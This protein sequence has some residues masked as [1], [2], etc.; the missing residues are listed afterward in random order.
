MKQYYFFFLVSFITAFAY[1]PPVTG[2]NFKDLPN[3]ELKLARVRDEFTKGSNA[4]ALQHVNLLINEYPGYLDAYVLRGDINANPR[5]YKVALD[6]YNFVLNNHPATA[7][8]CNCYWAMA[9]VYDNYFHDKPHAISLYTTYID[10]EL[11]DG[12]KDKAGAGYF[13]RGS[14]KNE[15]GDKAGYKEDL[16][17]GAALGDDECKNVLEMK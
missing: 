3:K 14:L 6:D 11:K 4:Q 10:T 7:Q 16:K 17:K 5:T 15:S 2:Q 13:F 8:K 12:N 1:T 9:S